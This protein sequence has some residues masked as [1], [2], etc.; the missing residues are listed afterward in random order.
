MVLFRFMARIQNI[1]IGIVSYFQP[2]WE[3]CV[4]CLPKWHSWSVAPSLTDATDGWRPGLCGVGRHC[5]G[6]APW[7]LE[8][9]FF[10]RNPMGT[11]RDFM[12]VLAL[13]RQRCLDMSL[14]SQWIAN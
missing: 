2:E 13:I 11:P 8:V 7:I 1:T 12:M 6:L 10:S 3:I 9:V 14:F 4:A 5:C